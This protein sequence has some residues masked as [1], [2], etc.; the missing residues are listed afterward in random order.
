MS[1]F[2]TPRAGRDTVAGLP[3]NGFRVF[4]LT[5]PVRG[6]TYCLGKLILCFGI[7]THTPRAGRDA[8]GRCVAITM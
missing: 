3:R 8:E 5:R 1:A 2:Y 6:A 4:H 7:S